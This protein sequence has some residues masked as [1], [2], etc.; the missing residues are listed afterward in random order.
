MDHGCTAC[1]ALY[2]LYAFENKE[3][4]WIKRFATVVENTEDPVEEIQTPD[5][6]EEP[7]EEEKPVKKMRLG[8]FK[9]KKY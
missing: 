6:V 9:R 1:E 2:N 8:C 3:W 4:V 5:V 7:A